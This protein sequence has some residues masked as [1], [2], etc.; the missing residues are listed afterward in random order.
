MKRTEVAVL[1]LC[2]VVNFCVSFPLLTGQWRLSDGV[3]C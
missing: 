2:F 1:L 3:S